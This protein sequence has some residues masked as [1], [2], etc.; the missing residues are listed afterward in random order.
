MS[1]ETTHITQSRRTFGPIIAGEA[2]TQS[3]DDLELNGASNQVRPGGSG[4]SEDDVGQTLWVTSGPAGWVPGSYRITAA[5]LT[6][7][8]WTLD[9]APAAAGASAGASWAIY[10]ATTD[11]AKPDKFNYKG[12]I[13]VNG[14]KVEGCDVVTPKMDWTR[15]VSKAGASMAY[16]VGLMDLVGCKNGAPFYGFAAGDVLFNGASGTYSLADRY[17]VTHRFGVSRGKAN[18]AIIPGELT[19]P[20]KRGWDY[21]WVRYNTKVEPGSVAPR[22]AA[23]FVEEVYPDADFTLIGIGR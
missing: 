21:L 15:T 17:S 1:G 4:V 20:Y 22:A 11:P 16:F 18:V 8:R 14:D 23:A 6:F 5:D 19:V 9:R 13:G 10:P 7:N 12:A 2:A 3:G